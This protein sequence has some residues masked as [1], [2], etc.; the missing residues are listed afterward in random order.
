MDTTRKLAVYCG[1]CQSISLL[2]LKS[3]TL[4]VGLCDAY[5]EGAI[6]WQGDL[7]QCL[8]LDNLDAVQHGQGFKLNDNLQTN[9]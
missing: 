3:L 7:D 2:L 9:Q 8:L 4:T 1:L 5:F 6:I